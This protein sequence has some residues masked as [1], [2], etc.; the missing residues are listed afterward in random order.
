MYPNFNIFDLRLNKKPQHV[1]SFQDFY[2]IF[3][4]YYVN[5]IVIAGIYQN[6]FYGHLHES[7]LLTKFDFVHF[8]ISAR[9]N[10]I[11]KLVTPFDANIC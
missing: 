4:Y 2:K 3:C 9:P 1:H 8:S 5:I 10:S 7:Y 6:L 11:W